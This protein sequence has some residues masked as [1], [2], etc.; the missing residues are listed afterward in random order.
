MAGLA[1][2]IY[3]GVWMMKRGYALSRA[4]DQ[5]AVTGWIMPVIAISL[6]GLLFA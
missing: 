5:A 2:G 6:L 3:G 4:A 1:S